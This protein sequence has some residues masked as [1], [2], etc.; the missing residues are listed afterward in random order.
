ME[1]ADVTKLNFRKFLTN[2]R[3][4]VVTFAVY[5]FLNDA[6]ILEFFF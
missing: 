4:N 1:I 3:V 6:V 2:C 5:E